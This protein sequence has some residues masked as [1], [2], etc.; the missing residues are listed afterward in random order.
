LA[1]RI[2]GDLGAVAGNLLRAVVVTGW[3]F[4]ER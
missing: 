1:S 4:D 2:V 3:W